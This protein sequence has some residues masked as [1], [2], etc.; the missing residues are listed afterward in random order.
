MQLCYWLRSRLANILNLVPVI[1]QMNNLAEMNNLAAMHIVSHTMTYVYWD[2]SPLQSR[3]S[4]S[5]MHNIP[6]LSQAPA[7]QR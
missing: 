6:N 4:V 7:G 1:K 3:H 2:F 5:V